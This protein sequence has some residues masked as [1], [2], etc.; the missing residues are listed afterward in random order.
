MKY[1]EWVEPWELDINPV[2]S[3]IT[4]TSRMTCEDAIKWMRYKEDKLHFNHPKYPYKS[5]QDALN[6]F[7][8][9]NWARI[10]DVHTS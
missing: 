8:A 9:I 10:I 5:D 6:D 3:P 7:I 1:V 2:V 4:V